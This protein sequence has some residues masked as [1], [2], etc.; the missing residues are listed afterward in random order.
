MFNLKQQLIV[1]LISAKPASVDGK[2]YLTLWLYQPADSDN[3]QICGGEIMKVSADPDLFPDFRSL[4]HGV[5][6]PLVQC[7]ITAELKT[8]AANSTK[9]HVVGVKAIKQPFPKAS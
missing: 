2:N 5:T 3:K 8:G 9:L 4:F 6:S 7:E 1:N